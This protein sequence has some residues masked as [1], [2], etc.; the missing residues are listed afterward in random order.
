MHP[1]P[2]NSGNFEE[3]S[4]LDR[5]LAN[6][7]ILAKALTAGNRTMIYSKLL[8]AGAILAVAAMPNGG[9]RR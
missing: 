8:G 5:P 7:L 1:Y 6:A 3:D 4:L 9:K 2:E